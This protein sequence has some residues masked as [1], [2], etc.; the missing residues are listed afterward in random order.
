MLDIAD[1][2]YVLHRGRVTMTGT[3]K[4][5]RAN[6]DAIES[7]YLANGTT[8]TGETE[9]DRTPAGETPTGKTTFVTD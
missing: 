3:P 5:L 2:V 6:L 9:A 1:R 7:S 4:E 8:A